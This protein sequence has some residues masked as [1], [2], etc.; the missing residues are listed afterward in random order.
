MQE[1]CTLVETGISE[2]ELEVALE[3]RILTIGEMLEIPGVL[4]AVQA[5]IPPNFRPL[6][7]CTPADRKS[8]V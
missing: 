8:V 5:Q 2:V 3:Q 6:C 7:S 4:E 1:T